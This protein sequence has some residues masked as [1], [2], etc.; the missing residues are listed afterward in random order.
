MACQSIVELLRECGA[1]G[2]VGGAGKLYMMAY[3]DAAVLGGSPNQ[4]IY[5]LTPAGVVS[6]LGR[7]TGKEFVEIGLLPATAGLNEEL[8]KNKQTGSSFLTQT[9]NVVLSQLTPA[10]RTF[11]QNTLNQPVLALV[12]TRN[13]NYYL[14]GL[15]GQ[16]EMTTLTG[17]TGVAEGDLQGY[18]IAYT[19]TD[20]LL[21]PMVD[22]TLVP[23]LLEPAP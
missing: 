16:L 22:P 6:D 9:L 8:T 23:E 12:K 15:G 18:T 7:K 21:I 11:V 14:G 19:G 10:N 3:N 4:L 5:A 20:S 17:G 2:I 13:N 1:D